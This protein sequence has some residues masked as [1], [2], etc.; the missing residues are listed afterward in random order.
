MKTLEGCTKKCPSNLISLV[1][2]P[3]DIRFL[4]QGICRRRGQEEADLDGRGV[5]RRNKSGDFRG[6]VDRVE[7]GK[8]GRARSSR[9]WTTTQHDKRISVVIRRCNLFFAWKLYNMLV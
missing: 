6:R 2:G 1:R 3:F 7:G 8:T 4:L 9:S 5:V